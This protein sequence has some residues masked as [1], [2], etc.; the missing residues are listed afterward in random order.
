MLPLQRITRIRNQWYKPCIKI[1]I[2]QIIQEELS[3]LIYLDI[4]T[5]LSPKQNTWFLPSV[6]LSNA[7]H[8]WWK[9][10]LNKFFFWYLYR[11]P[12]SPKSPK[13][14]IDIASSRDSTRTSF[15]ITSSSI[16]CF[17]PQSKILGLQ[18]RTRMRKVFLRCFVQ[19]SDSASFQKFAINFDSATGL[20]FLLGN[21]GLQI[22][23]QD[24]NRKIFTC[25]EN[26]SYKRN[27]SVVCVRILKAR[28]SP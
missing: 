2:F 22:F 16:S 4:Q 1:L 11:N 5:S 27:N 7:L 26:F 3:K 24:L 21:Y 28:Y 25:I 9:L 18:R 17:K 12:G 8:L 13:T 10:R 6:C 19:D 14:A 23:H 15:S 20:S